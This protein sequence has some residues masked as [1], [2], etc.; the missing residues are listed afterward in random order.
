MVS[1][2]VYGMIYNCILEELPINRDTNIL[3][4]LMKF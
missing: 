4:E 1:Y 2:L 3:E